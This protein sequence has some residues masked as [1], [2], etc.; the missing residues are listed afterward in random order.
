MM[1]T[2]GGWA[3]GYRPV[4]F[5]NQTLPVGARIGK[6]SLGPP[7]G[8]GGMGIVYEAFDTLLQRPVALKMMAAEV[9]RDPSSHTRFLREARAAA[10]LNHPSI[11]T[12]Y[13]VGE[14]E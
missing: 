8:A 3:E 11:V 2:S 7:L 14:H 12:I 9:A 10:R 1:E 5:R 6:Y 13:D 4:A